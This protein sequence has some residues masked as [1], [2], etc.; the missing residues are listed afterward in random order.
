[1][2]TKGT[3]VGIE[4]DA[5]LINGE[6]TYRGRAYHGMTIEGL[7][8]N[9]RLVQGVFDDRNLETRSRWDYP[10]GPFDPERNTAEFIAMM[11]AWRAA[12]LLSFTINLQGGSPEGY[13]KTQPWD[14]AAFTAAGEPEPAY[15]QRLGRI[16]DEADR[17]GMAPIL[18]L[19]Y[20][21]Q[22]QRLDDERAV[23]RAVSAVTDWLIERGDR[24]V[25]V[26]IANEVDVGHYSH[27]IIR[28]QRCHELIE[29][30][31]AR[32]AG[33][34][35]TPAGRLLTSTSMRGGTLP[36][37]PIMR[38]A[39]FILL[40]G[41]HVSGPDR[42]REMV[43]ECRANAA[44]RGQPILF[45]EDD[46]FDFD[47]DDNHMHAA[48]GAY[49]GWGYFD[50]RMAGGGFDEGYQSMPVNWQ[51]SSARKRGFFDLLAK[52]TGAGEHPQ[53][54]TGEAS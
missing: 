38:G 21:G 29:L 9:A 8:L 25:L 39:D 33:K 6:P 12:G 14:N 16:L 54:G 19:F 10:D 41:N 40:H 32:S 45:N 27:E 37:D 11:P 48:I 20:F 50:Y 52:I 7:L 28:A 35:A 42:I 47:A 51:T 36:P 30:V 5:F 44:Y 49:A 13:S 17:L 4:K 1:M 22:D 3:V 43:K 46:H 23:V 26:E 2:A 34:L 15:L 24:H 53:E 31:Q 18:G